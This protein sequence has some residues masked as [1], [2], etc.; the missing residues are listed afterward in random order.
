MAQSVYADPWVRL[1][2]FRRQ[3]NEA[4]DTLQKHQ[5]SELDKQQKIFELGVVGDF[6]KKYRSS[7]N[8]LDDPEVLKMLPAVSATSFAPI[9]QSIAGADQM[10]KEKASETAV[11]GVMDKM[12]EEMKKEKSPQHLAMV[13]ASYIP[14]IMKVGGN[15]QLAKTAI[16][17]VDRMSG[18]FRSATTLSPEERM[19]IEERY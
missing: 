3:V 5:Q 6:M 17:A 14:E 9:V 15:S 11:Q 10:R 13:A 1:A 4:S 2:D 16:E 8:G 12:S 18:L 19:A 7:P